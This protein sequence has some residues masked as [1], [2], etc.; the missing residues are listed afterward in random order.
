MPVPC[1]V[2]TKSPWRIGTSKLYPESNKVCL[3]KVFVNS[4]PLMEKLTL[5]SSILFSLINDSIKSL[6]IITIL[7]PSF[8]FKFKDLYSISLWTARALFPGIVQG[9]VVQ[10]TI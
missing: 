10:I 8:I 5:Y 1:S 7:F 9:V 2:V 6:A 4:W 3:Q